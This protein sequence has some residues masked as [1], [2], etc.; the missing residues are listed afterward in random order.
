MHTDIHMHAHMCTPAQQVADTENIY[1]CLMS[2]LL[3]HTLQ[4]PE[5]HDDNCVVHHCVPNTK[6]RCNT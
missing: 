2:V 3:N 1:D 6:I 5:V 4:A